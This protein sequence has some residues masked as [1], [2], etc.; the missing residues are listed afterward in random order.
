MPGGSPMGGS[1]AGDP[2]LEQTVID[3]ESWR[4]SPGRCAK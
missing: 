1:V 4:L 3:V 2:L